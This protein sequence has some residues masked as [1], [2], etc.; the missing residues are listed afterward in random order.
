MPVLRLKMWISSPSLQAETAA[1]RL[2]LES[3]AAYQ[4]TIFRRPFFFLLL[5]SFLLALGSWFLGS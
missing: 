1:L 4:G 2:Y 3:L 5:D